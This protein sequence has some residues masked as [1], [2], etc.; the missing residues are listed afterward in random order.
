MK[1]KP[2]DRNSA[3]TYAKTWALNRNP[4]YYDFSLIGGDCTN[5]VSQCIF[6]GCEQMNYTKDIGWYYLT[7]N[8]RAPAWTGVEFLHNFL[9]ANKGLGPFAEIKTANEMQLGDVVQLGDVNGRFYH[10]L[11]I[12][13][14]SNG[15]IFV[16]THSFDAIDRPL[17]SY[18]FNQ[19]RFLSIQGTRKN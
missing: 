4:K 8:N 11:L 5:Y 2:Y 14:I 9:I 7:A 1:I 16:S 10:S 13:K 17:S 15:E 3:L 12:T 18:V 19:I 6:A